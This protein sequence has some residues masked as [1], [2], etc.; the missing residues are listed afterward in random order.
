L[1]SHGCIWSRR[2]RRRLAEVPL[3]LDQP[4]WIE[5][6]DFDI[7]FHVR[8]LALP[9]PGDDRQL[10]AQAARLHARPL[11][12]RRP[13][14]ELYLIHG[15]HGGRYGLY[16]TLTW[17]RSSRLVMAPSHATGKMVEV[18]NPSVPPRGITWPTTDAVVSNGAAQCCA[19]SARCC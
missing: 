8:E 13:L 12:R 5:D 6:P 1:W 9:T 4:Y 14:W 10:A 2:F 15:L 3:G 17:A 18:T 16:Q 19:C 7:E 11:D